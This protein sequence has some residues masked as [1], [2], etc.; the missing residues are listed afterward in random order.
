MAG[1]C[2]PSPVGGSGQ[3][4]GGAGHGTQLFSPVRKDASGRNSGKGLWAAEK[5][6]RDLEERATGG[7]KERGT[8]GEGRPASQARGDRRGQAGHPTG[9]E[10]RPPARPPARAPRLQSMQEGGGRV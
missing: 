6:A 10:A 4:P 3:S 1:R 2:V 8:R 7:W 9:H 5:H